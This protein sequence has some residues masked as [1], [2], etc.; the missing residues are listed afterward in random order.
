MYVVL[1]YVVITHYLCLVITNVAIIIIT[2]SVCYY[3]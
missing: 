2:N 1:G 3:N